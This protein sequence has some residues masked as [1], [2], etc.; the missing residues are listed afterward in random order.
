MDVCFSP[1][2]RRLLKK[3]EAVGEHFVEAKINPIAS[4]SKSLVAAAHF[5]NLRV[6]KIL[7][8]IFYKENGS[9]K[10]NLADVKFEIAE[11]DEIK[12]N[13]ELFLIANVVK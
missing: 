11:E 1:L 13:N 9:G 2:Y 6:I 12:E 10:I 4:E 8:N 3:A 7:E 5:S